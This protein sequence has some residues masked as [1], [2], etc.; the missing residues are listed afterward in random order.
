MKNDVLQGFCTIENNSI[1]VYHT[2]N[3]SIFVQYNLRVTN[4]LETKGVHYS[5][6]SITLTLLNKRTVGKNKNTKT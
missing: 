3:I 1:L 2:Y 6:I 4:T 5:E